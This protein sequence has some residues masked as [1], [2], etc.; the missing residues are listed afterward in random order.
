MYTKSQQTLA[1]IIKVFSEFVELNIF[2]MERQEVFS[3]NDWP[4]YNFK[5]YP[6][7]SLLDDPISMFLKVLENV[8]H[9]EDI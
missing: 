5:N 7:I 6:Y 2:E 1:H 9:I 4:K 8:L 3:I